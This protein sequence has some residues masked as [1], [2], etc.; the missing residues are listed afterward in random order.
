MRPVKSK[1]R[2]VTSS[3]QH[4]THPDVVAVE[5]DVHGPERHGGSLDVTQDR[6][7]LFG[8]R[9]AAGLNPDDDNVFETAIALDDLVRDAHQGPAN[10]VA[11]HDLGTGN[12]NA[13]L[14]AR[15]TSLPIG[16]SG[17]SSYVRPRWTCFTCEASI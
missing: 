16:H 3:R 2:S 9:Y 14:R 11:V 5:R 17:S 10:L 7:E 4:R 13:P 15:R 8:Q 1:G 12:K 6:R